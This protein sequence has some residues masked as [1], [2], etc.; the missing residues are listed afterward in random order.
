MG[1]I[2]FLEFGGGGRLFICQEDGGG[3]CRR[4]L[5]FLN[6]RVGVGGLIQSHAKRKF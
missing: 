1:I 2:F 5:W 3:G 6:D 4:L